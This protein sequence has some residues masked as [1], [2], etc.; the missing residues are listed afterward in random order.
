MRPSAPWMR[1]PFDERRSRSTSR[2]TRCRLAPAS[3]WSRSGC[4]ILSSLQRVHVALADRREQMRHVRQVQRVRPHAARSASSGFARRRRL[5]SRSRMSRP[6]L[7]A[8]SRALRASATA[9]SCGA[10][11]RSARARA[12]RD[13][14]APSAPSGS[15]RSRSS[16]ARATAA[17]SCPLILAPWQCSPT[18]VCTANAKSIGVAPF[19]SWITS[20]VGREH[21][22]LV[23]IQVELQ[24]FQELV[25]RLGVELQLQHLP[26]PRADGARARPHSWRRP[27]TASARRSRTPRC[28]AC[29]ACGSGSRRAVAR[30][31]TPSCAA[32]DSR[33]TSAARCSP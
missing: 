23:L 5:I 28:G 20:P 26:E 4:R 12:S 22:D 27:C 33:S 10:R 19:G 29:R 3:A 17:R 7:R 31:R 14:A 21:E 25:R 32:T 1:T 30:A 18:S 16:S 11:A 2:S 8:T 24:E 6:E 15:R 13:S 9:G